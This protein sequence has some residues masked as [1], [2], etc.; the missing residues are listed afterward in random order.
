MIKKVYL[1]V[2]LISVVVLG[3]ILCLIEFSSTKRNDGLIFENYD[4]YCVVTGYNGASK[5][6]VIPETVNGLKVQRIDS[7]VFSGNDTLQSVKIMGADTVLYSSTFK[8][9]KNLESIII[10]KNVTKMGSNVF[11]DCEKITIYC[12]VTS[13]PSGWDTY[14][15]LYNC[16]VIWGY[17]K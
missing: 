12:E 1:T 8:N 2:V 6:V 17:N 10:P 5:N 14:W 15:N 13:K 11:L 9:C 7:G 4:D 3:V 16:P